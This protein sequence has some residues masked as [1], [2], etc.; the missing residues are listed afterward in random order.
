MNIEK[1]G[2]SLDGRN[3]IKIHLSD[4]NIGL[5]TGYN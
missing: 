2:G 5:K 1:D 4:I 3:I